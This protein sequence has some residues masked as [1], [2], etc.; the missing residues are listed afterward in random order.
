M[1]SRST[2][3][4]VLEPEQQAAFERYIR[5]G[6]RFVGIHSDQSVSR[7]RLCWPHLWQASSTRRR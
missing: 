2:T 1:A 3:G 4:H 7:S 6:G 5:L